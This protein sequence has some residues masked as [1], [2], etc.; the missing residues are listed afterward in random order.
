MDD[1]KPV[2]QK[3][4]TVALDSLKVELKTEILEALRDTETKLLGAF[5]QYQEH[6]SFRFQKLT[7]DVANIN[8]S[9]DLRLNNL[10]QRVVQLEKRI[11]M[12]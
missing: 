6:S 9:S 5:F 3:Q 1:N 10:E 8:A 4:L 11:M 2:T 7:A 12:P